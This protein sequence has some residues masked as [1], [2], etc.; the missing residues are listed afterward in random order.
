MGQITDIVYGGN[1][2]CLY[3]NQYF[4]NGQSLKLVNTTTALDGCY[5]TTIG[6]GFANKSI[7]CFAT[8]GGGKSNS[9]SGYSS[10]IL[11]G[12]YNTTNSCGCA[13]IVGSNITAN[14]VCATFVNNLSI[15]NI[16]T[17]SAGLPSKSVWSNL[18]ILNI[19]P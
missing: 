19:V 5:F 8:I 1:Y 13:M 17:S 15:V 2:T 3:T 7:G 10:A 6:G 11:G 18:G 14:R 9:A 4:T 16:P 12:Q